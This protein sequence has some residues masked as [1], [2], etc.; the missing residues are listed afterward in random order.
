M[1]ST[2]KTTHYELNQYVG[3]DKPTYLTDYNGDMLAIDTGIYNAQ[4]KAD[5][6]YS[7]AGIADGKAGDAQ[8]TA[9]TALTSAG[10][11]NTNIGTMA[12]LETT[13]KSSLV[14]AI[15]EV[16][17]FKEIFNVNNFT[18]YAGTD[19]DHTGYSYSID[20]WSTLTLATN[21]DKSLFKLYGQVK[22]RDINT[23]GSYHLQIQTSLNPSEAYYINP[24]GFF[25]YSS[26]NNPAF[27]N[28]YMVVAQINTNGVIDISFD[29]PQTGEFL[30]FFPACLY[31]NKSFG[32]E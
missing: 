7:S 13:E 32:D 8:T 29:A 27:T 3:T 15:N 10:T 14:G 5:S 18:T 23:T 31:F 9:N 1:A 6:A 26:M 21:T 24:I 12:N 11:A 25:T 2:N 30:L 20:S 17:S 28:T 4:T 16:N 19:M 22:V